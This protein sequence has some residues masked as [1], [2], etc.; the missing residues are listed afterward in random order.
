MDA[1]PALKRSKKRKAP[2]PLLPEKVRSPAALTRFSYHQSLAAELTNPMTH[3]E[4]TVVFLSRL[5]LL[6]FVLVS[7]ICGSNSV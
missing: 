4:N 1:G 6:P 3:C 2:A 5:C 7:G